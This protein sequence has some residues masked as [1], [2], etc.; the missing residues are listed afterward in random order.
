MKKINLN[1]HFLPWEVDKGL[2]VLNYI[3]ANYTPCSNLDITCNAILNFSNWQIDWSKLNIDKNKLV[4]ETLE[5]IQKLTKF[6]RSYLSVLY[7]DQ[8]NGVIDIY[9]RLDASYY[10][11]DIGISYNGLECHPEYFN[12]MLDIIANTNHRYTWISPPPNETRDKIN[13][14][15]KTILK[16]DIQVVRAMPGSYCMGY[17]QFDYFSRSILELVGWPPFEG[18]GPLD[19]FTGFVMT[20]I[21]KRFPQ[22]D[23]GHYYILGNTFKKKSIYE[24]HPAAKQNIFK[25]RQEAEINFFE[26]INQRIIEVSAKLNETIHSSI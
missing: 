20:E 16:K 18:Y 17:R 1:L 23:Y 12:L 26:K 9:H 2:T 25:Q 19:S 4:I 13:P 8:L 14:I 15:N 6:N 3:H 10:D 5:S 21:Y 7:S 11:G 24:P 22:L